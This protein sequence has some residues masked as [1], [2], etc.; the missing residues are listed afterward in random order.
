[1]R[2]QTHITATA[3]RH[4]CRLPRLLAVVFCGLALALATAS[5]ATAAINEV[6]LEGTG[7]GTVTSEPS[8]IDCTDIGGE[9]SGECATSAFPAGE[10]IEL[11]A[12]SEPG[13]QFEGWQGQ[14]NTGECESGTANPCGYSTGSGFGSR[15]ITAI[16]GSTAPKLLLKVTLTGTGD[17]EVT[18]SP[19]GISCGTKC[20]AEFS[21]GSTVTLT[22]TPAPAVPGARYTFGGWKGCT[23]V[24][25]EDK[26]EVTMSAAKTVEA[27]FVR[28]PQQRLTVEIVGG[29]SGEVAS[30]PSRLS[31]SGTCEAEFDEG[32]VVTLTATP[33]PESLFVGWS[34][35]G[36]SGTDTC[37]VT[38]ATATTITAMFEPVPPPTAATGEA[39]E[40]TQTTAMLAGTLDGQGFDTHFLFDYGE[41]T[42]FGSQ[43]PSNNGI[44]EDAGVVSTSTAETIA[45]SGLSPNTTYHY[46]MV[47]YNIPCSFFC[48]RS[49]PNTAEGTERTFT[50]LPLVPAVTTD[51][52]I[53]VGVSMASL[54][55][56]VVAQG[57]TTSYEVEYGPTDTFGSSTP[58]A[59]AGSATTGQYV[60]ANLEDLVPDTTYV[61]RF[62]ASNSGG[63]THGEVHTFTTNAPGEP[64]SR[65]LPPGFSL[66]GSSLGNPP[67]I[68]FPMLTSL[69]P[70]PPPTIAPEA[71]RVKITKHSYK[72][73]VLTLS[74]S[75]PASGRIVA[76]G[77][78]VATVKRSA[79]KAGTY[80]L[81]LALTKAG[82][83]SLRKHH[84]MTLKVKVAFAPSSGA[85]S[86]AT[87][88][89]TIKA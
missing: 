32:T 45:A 48:S 18:S 63:T 15:I 5:S 29:G 55:G 66:T 35:G 50:T 54:G 62:A 87:L 42:S 49:G 23:I 86:S 69:G 58:L 43:A 72:G 33:T 38:L 4:A 47:A 28:I 7:T 76:S 85:A 25:A 80:A 68:T 70:L 82:A 57:A 52:P 27:E 22:A 12:T 14:E 6:K 71:H 39:T 24:N 36:C 9:T 83:A 1:M 10:H 11:T 3:L 40:I 56:E 84:H 37:K 41:T 21:E 16:F 88:T 2:N 79:A 8:G 77:S 26:C 30:S 64:G 19:S 13:S 89:V 74:V 73:G 17:G 44:G 20:E 67:A 78:G 81:K 65:S 31:C 59:D 53:T 61:Y 60:T 75:A 51:V 46:K 34:G